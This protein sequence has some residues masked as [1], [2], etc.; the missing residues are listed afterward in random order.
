M[1]I[2]RWVYAVILWVGVI[3]FS[4]TSLAAEWCER[5]FHFLAAILF[6]GLRPEDPPFGFLH[7]LADKGFHIALFLVLAVLLWNAVPNTPRKIAVILVCGAVVGSA[8]EFLQRF[9]PGRDPAIRDVLINIVGT[10]IGVALSVSSLKDKIVRHKT[11]GE[12]LAL[13]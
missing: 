12:A 13:K 5:A 9:F 7:L 3:F 1:R 4:S 10:A 8:S 6:R 11:R 2:N